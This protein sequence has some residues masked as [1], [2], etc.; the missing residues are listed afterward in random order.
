MILL[1]KY[2]C[3]IILFH[4]ALTISAQDTIAKKKILNLNTINFLYTTTTTQKDSS[5][6]KIPAYKQGF[7]CN[8]EDQLNRKKVPLD[9]SLGNSKY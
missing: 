4:I 1:K 7:F 8:F 3:L 9:F 5:T 2:G 6:I